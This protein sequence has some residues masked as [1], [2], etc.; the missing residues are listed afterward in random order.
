MLSFKDGKMAMAAV[1]VCELLGL[2]ELFD[3]VMFLFNDAKTPGEQEIIKACLFR[4]DQS[5]TVEE[6]PVDAFIRHLL[7]EKYKVDNPGV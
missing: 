6:F 5:R 7:D 4:I 1:N 2:K 3:P